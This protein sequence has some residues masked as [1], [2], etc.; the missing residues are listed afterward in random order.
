MRVVIANCFDTYEQRIDLLYEYFHRA[1]HDVF[2][3]QSDFGHFTKVRR[4]DKKTDFIYVKSKPYY[5][6]MSM[7]RMLSHYKFA[8]KAFGLIQDLQPDLLYVLLP[9]NSLAKFA[10]RYKREHSNIML[11]F[12]IIDL[13]PE[14]MPIGK[15]KTLPPFT[16][17]KHLRDKNIKRADFVITECNLYQSVL[18]DSLK[19]IK[20]DTIYLA[21]RKTEINSNPVFDMDKIH[22]CYLGSINNIVDIPM[23]TKLVKIINK[24]KPV[25]L[26]IIG[27]GEM[28]DVLINEARSTGA[29]VEY[30][31]KVYDSKEKHRIFDKCQFGLNIMKETVCVGLT[32]KS[33][34]Y[35]EAGLPLLNNI[36]ADT[37]QI[38]DE[39]KIGINITD[40]DFENVATKVVNTDIVELQDMRDNTLRVFENLFSL[41]A[42]NKKLE[43]IPFDKCN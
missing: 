26:H 20:T 38:V 9:P 31:G 8:K 13:W 28:K 21:R 40:G 42:F 32:M 1:G 27:D 43:T 36:Q 37:A 35:F 15:I 23:I 33:I 11:Y 24:R 41:N 16:C 2:V 12:D 3:I 6:N 19:G 14:T 30:Y 25:V 39:Y 29:T 7:A 17:W 4:I 34:D 5:K 10:D 18:K 22:L